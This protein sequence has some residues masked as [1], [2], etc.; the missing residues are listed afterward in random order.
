MQMLGVL[1]TMAAMN[2]ALGQDTDVC[3]DE[4]QAAQNAMGFIYH[5]II[6]C[7]TIKHILGTSKT[8]HVVFSSFL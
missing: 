7:I 4:T 2:V 1:A 5:L 8:E 3:E 6:Q